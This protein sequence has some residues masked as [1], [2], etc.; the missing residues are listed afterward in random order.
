MEQT[1][2]IRPLIFDNGSGFTKVG[3]AGEDAPRTVFPSIVGRP[4]HRGVGMDHIDA[5]VGNEALQK[6]GILRMKFPLEPDGI[7]SNWEDMEKIWHHSF[8][9]ELRVP[10]EEHPVLLTQPPFNTKANREK[11]TQIMFETFK[12]PAMYAAIPAVLSLYASGLCCGSS[13]FYL[14]SIF[15][16]WRAQLCFYF[17][18]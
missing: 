7:V 12:I 11:M 1:E 8:H 17:V 2:D 9:E 13:P 5:L 4:R 3:F 16:W 10:P 14:G 18:D 15:L 6:R